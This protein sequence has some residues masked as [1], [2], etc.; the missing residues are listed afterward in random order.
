MA[1]KSRLCEKT[2]LKKGVWS[3]EEDQKL[4]SYIKKYG[5][6]NWTE[7]SKAAGLNRSGK[8]CR[9]RWVNYLRP[10]IKHGNFSQEEKE[11]I[12]T[13]HETLGNRWSAI[14]AKLPGRT[15]NEVKNYWH[16]HLK[17]RFQKQLPL[18]SSS[19][20]ISTS[21]SSATTTTTST[22]VL[23]GGIKSEPNLNDEA[24]S[25]KDIIVS[26]SIYEL[27]TD[28]QLLSF[29]YE[30]LISSKLEITNHHKELLSTHDFPSAAIVTSAPT[31]YEIGYNRRDID[32]N[33]VVNDTDHY[34]NHNYGSTINHNTSQTSE[35]IHHC[36]WTQVPG[37]FETR[38][39]NHAH[40]GTFVDD[41]MHP[42][43]GQ[44]MGPSRSISETMWPYDLYE[45][46]D[47]CNDWLNY[48]DNIF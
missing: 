47:V 7:M 3:P 19:I 31:N 42:N 6:W 24:A 21:T 29:P 16:T 2:H 5:I 38:E 39:D 18:H 41:Y 22:T 45:L 13:L 8:S 43:Y 48:M 27:A 26:N 30:P 32:Q 35:E 14:A 10:D 20:S 4:R 46:E 1:M 37:G 9:L 36:L 28:H 17:K 34:C 40:Q 15:D 23:L 44:V 33:E 25:D 12:V 11:I